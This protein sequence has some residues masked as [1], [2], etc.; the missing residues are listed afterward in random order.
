[1]R[2]LP[3]RIKQLRSKARVSQ[4]EVANALGI[5]QTAYHKYEDGTNTIPLNNL[6]ALCN[7]Y[8]LSITE[9]FAGMESE[10]KGG[11]VALNSDTSSEKAG[12]TV[13]D[14][15]GTVPDGDEETVKLFTIEIRA[16]K[17]ALQNLSLRIKED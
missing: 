10:I 2:G 16:N 1:M 4:A 12:Q 5:T 6:E 8:G 7:Y 13:P 17:Q 9:F 15:A 11:E 14:V 3:E